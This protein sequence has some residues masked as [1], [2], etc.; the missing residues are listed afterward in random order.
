LT[1]AN[2][3][4]QSKKSDRAEDELLVEQKKMSDAEL[5][6]RKVKQATARSA[7]LRVTNPFQSK[8]DASSAGRWGGDQSSARALANQQHETGMLLKSGFGARTTRR[9]KRAHSSS[10]SNATSR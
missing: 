7:R 10:S 8:A 5:T 3:E 4:A 1:L 6:L 2:A 9:R